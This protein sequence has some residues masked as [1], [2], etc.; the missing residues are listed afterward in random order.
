MY[1]FLMRPDFMDNQPHEDVYLSKRILGQFFRHCSLVEKVMSLSELQQTRSCVTRDNVDIENN[2]ASLSDQ[3]KLNRRFIIPGWQ[4]YREDAEE[5]YT[6]YV[7]KMREILDQ[8]DIPNETIVLSDVYDEKPD[9]SKVLITKL[10]E[11]FRDRFNQQCLK[12]AIPKRRFKRKKKAAAPVEKKDG[13]NEDEADDSDDN[14]IYSSD[15]DEGEE[16]SADRRQYYAKHHE[17]NVL[18][19]AWYAIVFEK[20]AYHQG[21]PLYGLPWLMW[22]EMM[23]LSRY[24]YYQTHQQKIN[25]LRDSTPAAIIDHIASLCPMFKEEVLLGADVEENKTLVGNSFHYK[26]IKVLGSKWF[27]VLRNT[28][29]GKVFKGKFTLSINSQ[30]VGEA[31]IWN[32]LIDVSVSTFG[33]MSISIQFLFSICLEFHRQRHQPLRETPERMCAQATAAQQVPSLQAESALEDIQWADELPLHTVQRI[34]STNFER[35]Y[36]TCFSAQICRLFAQIHEQI[37]QRD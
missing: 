31:D 13:A 36:R 29:Y 15:E 16:Q 10:F 37:R 25:L 1:Q 8:L 2:E 32:G 12:H 35:R 11:H 30:Q 22:S 6:E 17:R 24:I 26:V 19:S 4:K 5:V 21:Y 34:E 3:E 33:G 18:I 28:T 7:L 20:L 14:V 9:V 23:Y 27:E